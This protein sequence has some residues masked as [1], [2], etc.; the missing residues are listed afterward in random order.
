MRTILAVL[1]LGVVASGCDM[2]S[3]N[4]PSENEP[5]D[6]RLAENEPLEGDT[7]FALVQMHWDGSDFDGFVV[8]YEHRYTT[9]HLT[10]GETVS[11]EWE[12]TTESSVRLA[13]N[14][15]D[16]LNEQ[17][18]EV[19]A[20]DNEGGVDPTPATITF[21]TRRTV[22]PD[23]EIASPSGDETAFFA[24][25]Q[26]TDWWNG[27]T[28]TM[29]ATDD[30]GEVIEVAW[31]V[32]DGDWQWTTDTTVTIGPEWFT[33][34]EGRHKLRVTS[35][36]NTNL[37]DPTPD[38]VY[39]ELLRPEFSK[40]LLIVDET[41]ENDL[42][43]SVN[44]TD[45]EIDDYYTSLFGESDNWDYDAQGAPPRSVLGQYQLVLWHADNN[46]RSTPH[47]LPVHENLIRDYLN[48]GGD[49]IMS[50][51]RVL[52]S[53]RPQ[54]SFP[55]SFEPGSFVHDYLHIVQ[56]DETPLSGDMHRAIGVGEM[57]D[58]R[59][60]SV[61]LANVFPYYGKLGQINVIMERGGF[62]ETIYSYDG[63]DV[64]Y[65]LRPIGLQY[66]GTT[67]N[68]VVLGFPI[69]FLQEESARTLASEVLQR[70]G[71]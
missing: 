14:S 46:F 40:R 65:R 2:F 10:T 37:V 39:V 35:R 62:T 29:Q 49:F 53:F 18:F 48:V 9:T 38:S 3:T 4:P 34:L 71:Y 59:V 52:K 67:F 41:T 25:D 64:D 58:V 30:D 22:F 50:G 44:A 66:F 31:A 8:G 23:T 61:K 47:Q 43:F 63:L 32:D 15:S 51:W 45:A 33:P 16:E 57:S 13:F 60:D 27:V 70:M 55:A 56:A 42:P 24:L 26:A 11:T 19:R 6:T 54:T 21:Y 36:D 20:I 28:L 68:A 1:M 7:L 5:P 17:L 12:A 69:F